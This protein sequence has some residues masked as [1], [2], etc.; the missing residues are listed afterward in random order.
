MTTQ[1]KSPEMPEEIWAS[2]APY[3]GYWAI[4]ETYENKTK[5]I[6]A[7]LVKERTDGK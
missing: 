6:R 3:A 1:V 4:Q 5:Y 7:D 2:P